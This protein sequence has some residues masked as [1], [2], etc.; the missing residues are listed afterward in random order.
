MINSSASGS[1]R[2]AA[3]GR[4]AHCT[5]PLARAGWAARPRTSPSPARPDRSGHGVQPSVRTSPGTFAAPPAA[6]RTASGGPGCSVT[7][8]RS[9]PSAPSGPAPESRPSPDGDR[10]ERAAGRQQDRGRRLLC[11]MRRGDRRAPRG[12]L[13]QSG[14]AGCAPGAAHAGVAAGT[15]LRRRRRPPARCRGTRPSAVPRRSERRVS[16]SEFPALLRDLCG[17]GARRWSL[18][19]T[20]QLS[21]SPGVTRPLRCAG[22]ASRFRHIGAHGCMKG[23]RG[24]NA[25]AWSG[26]SLW[27]GMARSIR[28]QIAQQSS[29]ASHYLRS[30]SPGSDHTSDHRS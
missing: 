25:T 2:F 7:G 9:S 17:F 13:A 10:V 3:V 15:A 1:H 22:G 5:A 28:R 12:R 18:P 14:R 30:F 4:R 20:A 29:H 19:R 27:R 23:A 24:R 26:R 16:S 11:H 6:R 21:L 8:P